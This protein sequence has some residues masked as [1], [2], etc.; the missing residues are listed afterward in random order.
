MDETTRQISVIKLELREF[1]LGEKWLIDIEN[2]FMKRVWK[3]SHWDKKRHDRKLQALLKEK[4]NK[5]VDEQDD[6]KRAKERCKKKIVYNNSKRV[7]SEEEINLIS[8]GL[9]F[10]IK[11]TKFPLVEYIQATETLCLNLEKEDENGSKDRAQ[12]IRNIAIDHIRKGC[13]MKIK[14]NL[15]QREMKLLKEIKQDQL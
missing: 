11:P 2:H 4:R 9:N 7:F 14:S 3:N 13:R 6:I 15:T 5:R 10:G 8:L 1:E 12:K